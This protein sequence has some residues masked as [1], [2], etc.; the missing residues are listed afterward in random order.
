MNNI[1][2]VQSQQLVLIDG[3]G[4]SGTYDETPNL[5]AIQWTPSSHEIEWTTGRPTIGIGAYPYQ[6]HI[7]EWNLKKIE[8][9]QTL[10]AEEVATAAI[11]TQAA[12]TQA[13]RDAALATLKPK[14]EAVFT[15][16]GYPLTTE[17]LNII[18]G[19]G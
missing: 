3:V 12:A 7:D 8:A 5:H 9:D 2:Y 14:V 18:C 16:G 4:Y 10:V 1:T 6:Q 13:Q 15:A 17:E 11:D 19:G